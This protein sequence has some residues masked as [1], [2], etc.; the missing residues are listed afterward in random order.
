MANFT[1]DKKQLPQ[2][3]G[4]GAASIALFGFFGLKMVASPGTQA[5]PTPAPTPTA[6][7]SQ[8][9]AGSVSVTNPD[10]D[11]TVSPAS[12]IGAPAPS[13]SMRS[14]FTP[15]LSPTAPKTGPGSIQV[16]SASLPSA[17][18]VPGLP[19]IGQVQPLN[20]IAA[21]GP[22][23]WTVTGVIRSDT[24]PSAT[25]AIFR[26]GDQR[27]YVSIGQMVDDTTRFVGVDRTGV[28]VI[29]AGTRIRLSLGG[30]TPDSKTASST[31]TG[32]TSP[33]AASTATNTLPSLPTAAPAAAPAVPSTP[34]PVIHDLTTPTGTPRGMAAGD[35]GV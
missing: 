2:I 14:P 4:L 31:V 21:A 20:P 7:P 16:A 17:P 3:I 26:S 12:L 13:D 35:L 23:A 33:F 10:T 1:Y 34:P 15:G 29:Q 9:A 18:P 32:Q 19:S 30:P 8:E 25:I 24:D 11:A 27:R 6:Q 22:A 5:A 28:T